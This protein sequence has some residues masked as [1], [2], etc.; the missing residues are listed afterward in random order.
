ML[1][2]L[3]IILTF[4]FAVSAQKKSV[5]TEM[6]LIEGG[7]YTPLYINDTTSQTV[8]VESFLLDKYA[9]TNNE[10]LEF[11]KAVPKWKRSAVNNLF[12]LL[13]IRF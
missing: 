7:N 9:V 8:K 1:R 6:V 2:L 3:I 13:E 5:P 11:I 10:F 12:A 4:V